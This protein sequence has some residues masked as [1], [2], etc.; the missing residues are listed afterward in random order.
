MQI[1]LMFA[2]VNTKLLNTEKMRK[3]KV[4][5]KRVQMPNSLLII[6]KKHKAT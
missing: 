2:K 5:K 3:N 1:Y 4:K 6:P